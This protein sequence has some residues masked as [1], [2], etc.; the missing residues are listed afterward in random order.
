MALAATVDQL[1]P[2][3]VLKAARATNPPP[4][5]KPSQPVLLMHHRRKPV[6]VKEK[7]VR[8]S[9][10]LQALKA[11]AIPVALVVAKVVSVVVS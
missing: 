6:Q 2:V 11:Q 7:G 5:L 1:P 10:V 4:P 9:L 3:Q 8:A